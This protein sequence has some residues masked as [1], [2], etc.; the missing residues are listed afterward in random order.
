MGRGKLLRTKIKEAKALLKVEL[1][2]RKEWELRNSNFTYLAKKEFVEFTRRMQVDPIKIIVFG[3]TVYLVYNTLIAS[4][5]IVDRVTDTFPA[6]FIAAIG[7][8]ATSW[9]QPLIMALG[10]NVTEDIKEKVKTINVPLFLMALLL[11]YLLME[12]GDTIVRG[13][14]GL[15]QLAL[16][17]LS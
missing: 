14:T 13:T 12:H 5:I 2:A 11:A 8:Y 6:L 10:W 4:S 17:L 15:V 16:G 1:Q 9:M 7:G 3:G